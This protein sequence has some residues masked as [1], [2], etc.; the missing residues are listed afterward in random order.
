MGPVQ[1]FITR[2]QNSGG[3]ERA[4]YQLFLTELA[5]LLGVDKPDP[6]T[7]DPALDGYCFER[8]VKFT[9]TDDKARGFIDLYRRGSFILEAKQGVHAKSIRHTRPRRP[10]ET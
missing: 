3:S 8:P 7:G 10:W 6:A 2:W 9:H 5:A 1:D 4:N